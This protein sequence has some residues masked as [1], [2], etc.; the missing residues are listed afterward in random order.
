MNEANDSIVIDKFKETKRILKD[1][2][3]K[4]IEFYELQTE[5]KTY[6]KSYYD[7]LLN[8]CNR[9]K[10]EANQV[11]NSHYNQLIVDIEEEKKK[12]L[13]SIQKE[14]TSRASNSSSNPEMA[15]KYLN[16]WIL[17]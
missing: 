2:D 13:K 17:E 9:K 5:P 4:I 12:S 7:N 11:I 15:M 14:V 10:E 1:L 3:K 8:E 6:L 16:D